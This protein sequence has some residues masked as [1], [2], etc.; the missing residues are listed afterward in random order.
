MDTLDILIA[1][2]LQNRW[3]DAQ[4]SPR[5]WRRIIRRVASLFSP[6]PPAWR[7]N[8][9]YY[10]RHPLGPVFVTPFSSAGSLLLWRYDLLLM[11]VA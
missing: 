9:A 2:S 11:R 7:N 4:P 3:G 6:I 1:Q 10:P 5:V 8:P